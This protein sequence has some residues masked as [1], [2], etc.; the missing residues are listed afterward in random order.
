[1]KSNKHLS[2]DEREKITILQS[3]GLSIRKIAKELD[4]SPSTIS[5]E[6]KRKDALY[7]RNV[8]IGSQT[9][10]IVKKLWI[11]SHKRPNNFLNQ[12]NVV[13]FIEK[14]LQYG[15]SPAIITYLLKERFEQTISIE[16]LYTYIYTSKRKLFKYLLRRKFGRISRRIREL[17][18]FTYTGQGKNIP[19]RIDITLRDKLAN[20]RLEFGHFEADSIE[21][22]KKK[23]KR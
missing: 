22:R 13:D 3:Q 17:N 5:R 12:R 4:R 23:N 6:L 16:T 20:E 14:Y 19:N 9:H 11:K 8:Y 18:R 7:Y 15:Y 10:V 21:S 1:M 2:L